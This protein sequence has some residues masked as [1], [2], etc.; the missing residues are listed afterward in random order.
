MNER[1]SSSLFNFFKL[2]KTSSIQTLKIQGSLTLKNSFLKK[3]FIAFLLGSLTITNAIGSETDQF[4]ALGKQIKDSKNILN[5]ILKL[6][7]EKAVKKAND[8]NM[9]CYKL[10]EFFGKEVSFGKPVL[11]DVPLRNNS[12]MD[13]VPRYD[14]NRELFYEE[15]IFY[16]LRRF[17]FGKGDNRYLSPTFNVDGV[18]LGGDKISHITYIG[19]TYY[20]AYHFY[21]ERYKKNFPIR[22]A[23]KK[24]VEKAINFGIFQEQT[25]TGLNLSSAGTFS[26]ADMEANY[27]G[28]RLF[29]GLCESENPN[30]KKEKGQ[31]VVNKYIDISSFITPELD[32]SYNPNYFRPSF[33]RKIKPNMEKYC[34]ENTL[35]RLDKIKRSYSK[36]KK[37]SF[38]YYYLKEKIRKGE[39][40]DPSPFSLENVCLKKYY[41]K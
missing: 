38:S 22:K 23:R 1:R 16:G 2:K 7:L 14:S 40:K 33:W 17:D 21:F 3:Y 13:Q 10:T 9:S 30:L 18:R 11:L 28:L 41:N 6:K 4:L 26:Y 35:R 5:K 31:W 29:Y 20:K 8:K 34:E 32:E 19:F 36:F 25:I 24:A 27:Q 37:K 12:E 15:S 39:L